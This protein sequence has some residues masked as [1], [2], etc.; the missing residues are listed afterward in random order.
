VKNASTLSSSLAGFLLLDD[1]A[2]GDVPDELVCFAAG[3]GL[4]LGRGFAVLAIDL[5]WQS[6]NESREARV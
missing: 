6:L 3:L 5:R 4:G 1:G 2:V